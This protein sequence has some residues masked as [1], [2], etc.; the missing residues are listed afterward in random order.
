PRPADIQHSEIGQENSLIRHLEPKDK[1]LYLTLLA[2]FSLMGGVVTLFGAALSKV[3][4]TYGWSYTEAGTVYA[5]AS[6]G[7]FISS[8][9][10]G[11]L[12]DHFGSKPVLVIGLTVEAVSLM[13]FARTPSVP[14]NV[15]LYFL[16]GLGLGSNEAITNAAVVRIEERGKSRLM[17]LMH[18]FWCVGAIVG[19]LGVANLIRTRV[20]WRVVFPVF[21]VLIL[22]LTALLL[23][24]QFPKPAFSRNSN[25]RRSASTSTGSQVAPEV[26]APRKR[27]AGIGGILRSGTASFVF[28][29]AFAIFV[30]IGVE[31]GVYA[32]VSVFFVQVIGSSVSLG[33]AMVA[34]YWIGQFLG[35]LT[36]SVGYHGNRIERV[37]L[38]LSVLTVAALL[39]L[40]FVHITWIAV[41]ATFVAGMANSG[42][43]P[44]IISL[45]GKYSTRGRS[46]GIVTSA[47]GIA[48]FLFPVMVAT[49]SDAKGIA[50]GFESVFYV[51][52]ALLV[53]SLI[54]V[55]RVRRLDRDD[56]VATGEEVRIA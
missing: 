32:W 5:A 21:G 49:I 54:V 33:A 45:T 50:V 2:N 9:L 1:A 12:M 44:L 17:N 3:I 22:I 13:F 8:L 36:I 18:A 16:I 51:S 39:A 23:P 11:F 28:L 53:V 29:S 56:A 46:V 24:R 42:V 38:L 48:G 20:D 19:P 35:R 14:L 41:A 52:V 15:V 34:L 7:F 30:Y 6:V 37:L 43:F 31:K 10:T 25:S 40:A 47:G 4:E 27:Q 55:A 26:T